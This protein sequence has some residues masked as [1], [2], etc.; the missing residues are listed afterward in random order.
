MEPWGRHSLA[1]GELSSSIFAD[2]ANLQH[3]AKQYAKAA[4]ILREAIAQTGPGRQRA[5]MRANLGVIHWKRSAKN[6]AAFQLRLALDEME[7]AVGPEHPDVAKILEDYQEVLRK[8]GQK[9][10]AIAAAKRAAAIRL[11]FTRHTSDRRRVVDWRDLR[12]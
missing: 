3:A 2:L 10:E 4:D 7:A 12:P 1:D 6:E 11:A 8:T 9:Q 5:R